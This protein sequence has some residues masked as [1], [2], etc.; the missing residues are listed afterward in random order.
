LSSIDSDEDSLLLSLPVVLSSVSLLLLLLLES[1]LLSDELFDDFVEDP[2]SVCDDLLLS[3]S[4]L[5][6]LGSGSL[7]KIN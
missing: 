1:S 3:S 4:P 6:V 5:D 2:V 7:L